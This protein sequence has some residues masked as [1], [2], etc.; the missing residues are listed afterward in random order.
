MAVA[1]V[2]AVAVALFLEW[3]EVKF[4]GENLSAD[5]RLARD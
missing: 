5:G 4:A 1:V 3:G 2:V